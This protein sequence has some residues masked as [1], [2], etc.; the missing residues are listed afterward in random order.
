MEKGLDP[1]LLER[2]FDQIPDVVFFVKD[3]AG[4]YLLVNRT[5]AERCGMQHKEAIIGRTAEEIFPSPLGASYAA[6]DRMVLRG[7]E[8]R[9][10]LELH[11]YPGR[12]EGWCLTFKTPLRDAGGAVIGLIGISRDV[13]P[14]DARHPEYSDLAKAAQ[15]LRE[16]C[17]E[18]LRVSE[19]AKS[20]GL[21]LDRFERA[22]R[23]VFHLT[24]QQ[25]LIRARLDEATRRLAD[26]DEDIASI[27]YASGFSDHSAFTRRFRAAVGLTPREYRR[28][29]RSPS[30]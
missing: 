10:K 20:A 21:S 4:R 16:R 29:L 13:H 12:A 15:I 23:K 27:A 3:R 18:P 11:W 19:V 7:K 5:L 14:A 17:H 26:T 8:I 6:Q 22:C 28:H 24:P 2:L 30:S 25:L 1:A 9:D